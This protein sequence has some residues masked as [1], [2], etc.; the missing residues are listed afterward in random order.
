MQKFIK[1]YPEFSSIC[2]ITLLCVLF[3][4]FG[5]VFYPSL[6]TTGIMFSSLTANIATH[7]NFKNLFLD[8][9]PLLNNSAFYILPITGIVKI[10]NTFND[11]NTQILNTFITFA[12]VFSTYFM[13]KHLLSR[14]YGIVSAIL[15]ATSLGYIIFS[16]TSILTLIFSFL[17]TTALYFGFLA[18][19][20][21]DR[22]KRKKYYCWLF[23]IFCAFASIIKGLAGLILPFSV[24]L[25]YCFLT[26]RLKTLFKPKYFLVGLIIF[27]LI[28][29]PW[30]YQI[31][32]I[33]GLPF[34]EKYSYLPKFELENLKNIL[35][36]GK[37][38]LISFMPWTIL[39]IGFLIN[40]TKN[41][42]LR[43]KNNNGFNLIKVEQKLN[44]MTSIYF[45]IAAIAITL[46]PVSNYHIILIF[47][48][49][50]LLTASFLYS[51]DVNEKFKSKIVTISTY[52]LAII[53]T[54]IL[55]TFT[56]L[57]LFLPTNIF[58]QSQQITNITL[59]VINLLSILLLLKLK[60]KS[61]L[62]TIIS[63]IVAMVLI[64][65]FAIV[66]ST[67]MFY[68]SGE[69]ELISFS[70]YAES[71]D[72]KLITYNL[73]VKP[74]MLMKDSDKIYFLTKRDFNTLEELLKNEEKAYYIILKN[75]DIQDVTSKLSTELYTLDTGDKYSLLSNINMP[76]K[77]ISLSKFYNRY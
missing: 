32:N 18:I 63:Y 39:F 76:K 23:Y 12:F 31:Y 26:K 7:D 37:L 40:F 46:L 35:Y 17:I 16:H 19:I 30:V 72:S 3:L 27:A 68:Y 42:I 15:I 69:N 70:K 13:G 28:D 53:F 66:H 71:K 8:M 9:Q 52:I 2:L 25:I 4:F 34:I 36:Y 45:V 20:Q 65:I 43:I 38:F 21:D 6:N 55:I 77:S 49:A 73:Q 14:M 54:V 50:S 24:M 58:E 33:L 11:M 56:F 1:K 67:N 5:L 75:K 61:L 44:L 64:L 60:N 10:L 29:L 59:I 74:R 62:T 48:S 51:A 41:I 22:N 57:Y 47:P